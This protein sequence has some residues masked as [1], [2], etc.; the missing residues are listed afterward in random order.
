[1]KKHFASRLWIGLWTAMTLM[2][3][4][5]DGGD[6]NDPGDELNLVEQQISAVGQAP[7]VAMGPDGRFAVV[8]E[9]TGNALRMQR[10]TAGGFKDGPA[11]TVGAQGVNPRISF[12]PS[13]ESLVAWG[14]SVGE[15]VKVQLAGTGGIQQQR[16]QLRG[17]GEPRAI[18]SIVERLDAQ[19][20]S[21]QQEASPR[22]I[23][24]REREHALQ[25]SEAAVPLL[26]VEVQDRL[27]V[28]PALERVA[29][30][31]EARLQLPVVVDLAV[32]GEPAA[33]VL[34]GHRLVAADEVDDLEPSRCEPDR[35]VLVESFIVG[36]AMGE[37][38]CHGPEQPG[39]ALPHH[40]C[41]PA[42]SLSLCEP[43]T[44]PASRPS[45]RATTPR[46]PALPSR[47]P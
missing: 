34:V 32:E 5:S 21:S 9:E 13:G 12:G 7:S 6:P 14:S 47:Q 43:P 23:P 40:S 15:G 4:G 25:M 33:P 36:A 18:Q 2:G 24:Q 27:A 8:W 31:L 16:L 44:R 38:A 10:F 42:H 20:V 30:G 39:V 46:A 1:M 22:P 3:C 41:D 45:P 29:L 19:R 11:I 35:V 26:L 37:D 28:A 17:E